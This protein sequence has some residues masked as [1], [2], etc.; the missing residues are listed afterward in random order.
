MSIFVLS[1]FTQKEKELISIT[2]F[3][4]VVAKNDINLH[5]FCEKA[6]L[7]Y[8]TIY[9]K[10]RNDRELTLIESESVTNRLKE[11]NIAYKEA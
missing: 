7:I 4:E 10:M 2:E 9:G 6:G 8:Q 1:L 3:K 5:I 11:L